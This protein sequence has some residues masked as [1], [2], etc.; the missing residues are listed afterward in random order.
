MAWFEHDTS[1]IYFEDEGTGNETVLFLPGL[2]DSISMH[3]PLRRARGVVH[4]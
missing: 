1:R 2:T 3:E 4:T